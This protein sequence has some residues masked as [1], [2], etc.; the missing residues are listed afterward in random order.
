ME[1]GR[2]GLFFPFSLVANA[3]PALLFSVWPQIPAVSSNLL[4]QSSRVSFLLGKGWDEKEAEGLASYSAIL[5]DKNHVKFQP[6]R[7]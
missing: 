3:L 6:P 4:L 7:S 2:G 1:N 5:G